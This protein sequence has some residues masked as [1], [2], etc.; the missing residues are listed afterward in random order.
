M[1]D[2]ALERYAD[3]IDETVIEKYL[4]F[5]EKIK[6]HAKFFS[7]RNLKIAAV[8]CVCLLISCIA[9]FTTAIAIGGYVRIDLSE[10]FDYKAIDHITITGGTLGSVYHSIKNEDDIKRFCE[11]FDLEQDLYL[12]SGTMVYDEENGKPEDINTNV[13]YNHCLVTVYYK[14]SSDVVFLDLNSDNT[15]ILEK[16]GKLYICDKTDLLDYKKILYFS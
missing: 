16:D 15:F 4:R 7:F 11:M 1:N 12:K 5:E 6:T 10:I 13:N 3:G 9:T 2:C 14:D 8:A